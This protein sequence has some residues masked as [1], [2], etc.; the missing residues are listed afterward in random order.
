MVCFHDKHN[1]KGQGKV[2]GESRECQMD[3]ISTDD[4]YSM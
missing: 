1:F 2:Y 4:M 3:T